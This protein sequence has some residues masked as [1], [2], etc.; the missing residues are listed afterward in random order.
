[1]FTLLNTALRLAEGSFNRGSFLS[2]L[3]T[4]LFPISHF[5]HIQMPLNAKINVSI[6][7][8]KSRKNETCFL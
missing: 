5:L 6:K 8:A 1:M 7:I 3:S 4:F 2:S